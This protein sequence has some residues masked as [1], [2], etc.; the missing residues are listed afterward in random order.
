MHPKGPPA[1][2]PMSRLRQ[3]VR[4]P[5]S[6]PAEHCELCGLALPSEHSH[7]LEPASRKLVC[8]CE[9]CAILFSG[10][11]GGRY[12]RGPRD[13]ESLPG[14]RLSDLQWEDLHLPI[15]LTFFVESPPARRVQALCP[16]PAGAVESAL[17][18]EAWQAL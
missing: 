5:Q 13:R 1:R 3:F 15:N 7:L 14:S 11:Q 8:S 17:T 10:Q 6:P 16:R 2:T 9:P 18:L 4:K 12:R